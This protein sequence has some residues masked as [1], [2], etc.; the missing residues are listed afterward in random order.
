MAETAHPQPAETVLDAARRL[1][2]ERR[3]TMLDVARRIDGE[4]RGRA[5]AVDVA[6][7]NPFPTQ[8]TVPGLDGE[9]VTV[10][11]ASVEDLLYAPG[12]DTLPIAPHVRHY[13]TQYCAAW[14]ASVLSTEKLNSS[15][16][17]PPR[18]ALV[19]FGEDQIHAMLGLAAD[20]SVVGAVYDQ[21]TGT[22]TFVVDSP[23]LPAKPMWNTPPLA[24][25]LPVSASY[26]RGG[27]R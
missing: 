4:L 20:E 2:G 7:K 26:E 10:D 17:A 6:G 18:R 23:R 5:A 13:V 19:P 15:W 25:S 21:I 24:I 22:L 16:P 11:L 14:S 9:P 12:L 1:D 3:D 8:M 27:G